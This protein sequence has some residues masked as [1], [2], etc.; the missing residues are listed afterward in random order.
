M[1]IVQS[2]SERKAIQRCFHGQIDRKSWANIIE[3]FYFFNF[4]VDEQRGAKQSSGEFYTGRP[5][6]CMEP[7]MLSNRKLLQAAY[8]YQSGFHIMQK[9]DLFYSTPVPQKVRRKDDI[10][11][12]LLCDI[13]SLV[14]RGGFVCVVCFATGCVRTVGLLYAVNMHAC[15]E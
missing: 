4:T 3:M 8:N 6:L 2:S 7:K 11:Y 13:A 14:A 10:S 1:C 15:R 9:L 12:L 5:G